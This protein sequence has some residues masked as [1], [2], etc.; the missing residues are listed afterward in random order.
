MLLITSGEV[1]AGYNYFQ[2]NTM[3]HKKTHLTHSFGKKDFIGDYY[4]LF[5][6]KSQFHF[7]AKTDIFAYSIDKY[8]MMN[9]L[10]NNYPVSVL[11][12]F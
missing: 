4:I 11:R 10:N 9:L 7:E 6:K 3:E 1:G 12:E 8:Y 5:N 2:N